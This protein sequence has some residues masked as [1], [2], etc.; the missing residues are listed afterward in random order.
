[1]IRQWDTGK[2]SIYTHGK[3]FSITYVLR[4]Y[5]LNYNLSNFYLSLI[6]IFFGNMIH[7]IQRCLWKWPISSDQYGWQLPSW[8][9][10][11][12]FYVHDAI[13]IS[14]NKFIPWGLNALVWRIKKDE[15]QYDKLFFSIYDKSLFTFRTFLGCWQNT[16]QTTSFKTNSLLFLYVLTPSS[17]C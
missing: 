6:K 17:F 8:I 16:F 4:E 2:W 15:S 10:Q 5:D 11:I 14:C 3:K 12:Y 7:S 9:L 1:M 13:D